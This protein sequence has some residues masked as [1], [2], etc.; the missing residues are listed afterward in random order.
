MRTYCAPRCCPFCPATAAAYFDEGKFYSTEAGLTYRGAGGNL[1]AYKV[2][3][4][5][6]VS[7]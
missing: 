2:H 1:S 7:T 6:L 4:R 3:T 5:D